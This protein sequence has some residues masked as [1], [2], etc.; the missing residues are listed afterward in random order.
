MSQTFQVKVFNFSIG[1]TKP[2]QEPA[3]FDTQGAAK[4]K[5]GGVAAI[6]AV[7]TPTLIG[8]FESTTL[9]FVYVIA[10]VTTTNRIEADPSTWSLF[11][12]AG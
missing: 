11:T 12:F 6:K 2:V 3:G 5:T 8:C 4:D 10:I 1:Y 7:I 9:S